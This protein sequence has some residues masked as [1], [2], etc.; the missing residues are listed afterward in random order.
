[1]VQV[2][3]SCDVTLK[4]QGRDPKVEILFFMDVRLSHLIKVYV[5]LC[6]VKHLRYNG[7]EQTA[8]GGQIPY[9]TEHIIVL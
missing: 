9:S 3:C 6:Y 5:M 1:M 2:E 7:T 4:G 8:A